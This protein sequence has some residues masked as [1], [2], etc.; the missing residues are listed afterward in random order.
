MSGR[1]AATKMFLLNSE[2][3]VLWVLK[4]DKDEY[5]VY[6]KE[7]G[8]VDI[9][10]QEKIQEFVHG[11][12]VLHGEFG[13]YKYSEYPG[14]MKPNLQKLDKFIGIDTTGKTY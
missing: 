13:P 10:S 12:L 6:D 8:I 2:G 9:L 5:V 7:N 4:H 14:S 11:D 1:Q 3:D